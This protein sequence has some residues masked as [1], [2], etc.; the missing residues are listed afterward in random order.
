MRLVNDRRRLSL[1]GRIYKM[2]PKNI[3]P[4]HTSQYMQHTF[5]AFHIPAKNKT[6]H[7]FAW[8][9]GNKFMLT[10][11]Y[12]PKEVHIYFWLTHL[13]FR[14]FKYSTSSDTGTLYH[15]IDEWQWIDKMHSSK[16]RGWQTNADQL[17]SIGLELTSMEGMFPDLTKHSCNAAGCYETMKLYYNM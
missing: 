14:A 4:T 3:S 16:W 7:I 9:G 10:R 13:E 11:F 17:L 5:M 2:I 8:K 6:S 12:H 1:A 15:M